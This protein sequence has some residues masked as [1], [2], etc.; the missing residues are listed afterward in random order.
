MLEQGSLCRA[1]GATNMNNRSSRSHAIFTITLEQR[2][3]EPAAAA[4][5]AASPAR[6]AAAAAA[7]DAD[8]AAALIADAAAEEEEEEDDEEEEGGAEE[9]AD[10]YLLAKMHLV[11][12][13]RFWWSRR[14]CTG[15]H[16][17]ACPTDLTTPPMK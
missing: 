17:R 8:A 5:R 11:D 16:C 9:A 13:V 2:R 15:E 6:C 7:G 12:L 14:A 4:V 10:D 1:V 3:Q